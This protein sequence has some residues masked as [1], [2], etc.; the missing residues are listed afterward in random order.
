MENNKTNIGR[1][2]SRFVYNFCFAWRAKTMQKHCF[3]IQNYDSSF[4]ERKNKNQTLEHI[5]NRF[6]TDLAPILGS[7]WGPFW[8]HFEGFFQ[9]VF[10]PRMWHLSGSRFGP[11]LAPICSRQ[12]LRRF[13]RQVRRLLSC[14][15]S[16]NFCPK[17]PPV[18][19]DDGS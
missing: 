15:F 14:Q 17:F 4:F 7:I 3:F 10:L 12:F 9:S 19:I 6:R 16:Q 1:Y 11:I 18:F 13:S 5:C 2:L 8:I